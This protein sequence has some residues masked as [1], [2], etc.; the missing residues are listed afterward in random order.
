MKHGLVLLTDPDYPADKARSLANEGFRVQMATRPAEVD[1][2]IRRHF[3]RW[4]QTPRL[5][6]KCSC[7]GRMVYCD[8]TTEGD[9]YRCIGRMI[10]GSW[11]ERKRVV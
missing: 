8:T 2:A 11:C 6:E 10:D 7:G 5:E 1:R 9:V 4:I 3:P